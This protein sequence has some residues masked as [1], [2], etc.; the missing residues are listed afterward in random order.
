MFFKFLG[1]ENITVTVT[2]FYFCV[3]T[4]C[5]LGHFKWR[6]EGFSLRVNEQLLLKVTNNAWENALNFYQTFS[7]LG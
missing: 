7:D 2:L 4:Q 6:R 3:Q 5:Y 1:V